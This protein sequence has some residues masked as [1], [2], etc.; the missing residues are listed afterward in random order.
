MRDWTERDAFRSQL[1]QL[2]K[3]EDPE[4]VAYIQSLAVSATRSTERARVGPCP[5]G[6]RMTPARS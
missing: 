5:S 6:G 1:P 2:V 4:F 3:G